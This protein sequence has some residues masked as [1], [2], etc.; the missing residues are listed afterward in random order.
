[1]GFLTI[2][3]EP[4]PNILGERAVGATVPTQ[5]LAEEVSMSRFASGAWH[6]QGSENSDSHRRVGF[7]SF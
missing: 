5:L 6:R 7:S 1:M 3:L 4:R 2:R